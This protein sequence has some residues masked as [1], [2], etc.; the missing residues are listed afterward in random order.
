MAI[1]SKY[2][3]P[4]AL[5][6]FHLTGCEKPD[7]KASLSAGGSQATFIIDDAKG[8]GDLT[9]VDKNNAW[10]IP[11]AS[12]FS[13][14]V[15]MK[16]R[17]TRETLR[18][19][20][21]VVQ[22]EDGTEIVPEE[23]TDVNGCIKWEE[24]IPFNFFAGRSQR[25]PITRQIIG[26]NVHSGRAEV[27][28][29]VNPWAVGSQAR[30]KGEAV[31]FLRDQI[32]PKG[33]L[34]DEKMALKTLSGDTSGGAEIWL[35][36][37]DVNSIRR[38]SNSDGSVI[39][40]TFELRPKLLVKDMNGEPTY[41]E[42]KAGDFD[43]IAH[44]I[45]TDTGGNQKQ[46][47]LLT[48]KE[49]QGSAKL[50][51]GHLIVSTRTSLERRVAYGNMELALQLI[52]K[53]TGSLTNIKAY[54]GIFELGAVHE[55][56][57]GPRGIL[58]ESCRKEETRKT[59]ACSVKQALLSTSNFEEMK[60]KGEALI[61]EPY[62]FSNLKLRFAMV[63]PGE[64]AT[65]RTVLYTASTCIRD[66]F[67]GQDMADVP[68]NIDYL[69]EDGKVIPGQS[70]RRMTNEEGCLNWD[71]TIF[72][73][74]YDPER[75]FWKEIR[76]SLPNGFSRNLKFA[77]NPWDD[78]FTFGWDQREFSEQFI[79]NVQK[80][81]KIQSRF[82]LSNFG[83]H[84]VRFLYNIDR[85]MEL[86]VKKTV[87]ME[88][89]PRVLR[90][91]GIINARKQT[92]PLR[93]GI[94]LLKVGIQKDFLD[95]SDRGRLFTNK[96][97][98]VPSAMVEE[99]GGPVSRKEYITTKSQLVRVVDGQIIHPVELTMRDLRLMRIRS[100]FMIQLETVD[101]RLVTGHHVLRDQFRNDIE[102]LKK[103]RQE[104]SEMSSDEREAFL[105]KSATERKSKLESAFFMLKERLESGPP[106]LE[107][108]DLTSDESVMKL[109]KSALETNDFTEVKFPLNEDFDLNQFVEKNSG[110]EP[111][112]FVGPVIFLSNAYSDSVRATDNLDEARCDQPHDTELVE[113]GLTRNKEENP[114]GWEELKLFMD[115]TKASSASRQNNAYQFSKYY[116]SLKHLCN[117]SVDDLIAREKVMTKFYDENMPLLASIYNFASLYNLEF[118]SLK[119]EKLQ[120]LDFACTGS[121]EQCLRETSELTLSRESAVAVVNANVQRIHRP[122]SDWRT[123]DK[124][125]ALNG[126]NLNR[127]SEALFS[128][129][130]KK[131]DQ[132][133]V[134]SLLAGRA[135][136]RLSLT[137]KDSRY[138]GWWSR[139][140]TSLGHDESGMSNIIYFNCME[141]FSASEKPVFFEDRLRV[142]ETGKYTFLGG[143][144]LNLNVAEGTSMSRSDSW[145]YSIKPID[146]LDGTLVATTT[147]W[148]FLSA[149]P[150]GAMAGAVA[151]I[152][153]GVLL[154]GAADVIKPLSI[155]NGHGMS[156][157]DGTSVSQSTYIVAQIARFNIELTNYEYC[158]VIRFDPK[159]AVSVSNSMGLTQ[160]LQELV[161]RGLFVCS[162]RDGTNPVKVEEGY[163]YFTQHFTEGDM[164]DQADIY[165]HP[166]LLALRGVREFANF[167]MATNAQEVVN[168]NNFL[169][170]W[171]RPE[172]R[173]LA[174][175]LSHMEK[176]YRQVLPSFPG[177]YTL[178][179]NSEKPASFPLAER[180]STVDADINAEVRCQ[181]NANKTC[182]QK[183]SPLPTR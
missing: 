176:T 165:N 95:P 168:M 136:N 94:Y 34:V 109:L 69:D 159:F 79:A 57:R 92:E 107:N 75:L 143:L 180:L 126:L 8:T 91:S 39:D 117:K 44:L 182:E 10:Q 127:V 80:R 167:V 20:R 160:K 52:P 124:Q 36:N 123:A 24:A 32:L 88:L 157:S 45:A 134:C 142:K 156:N 166:W 144:Q 125:E 138:A 6:A 179:N 51:D 122:S 172:K 155:S 161:A 21:F 23:A 96:K 72:H 64:T 16:D 163:F 85:Y 2:L 101:E 83:Y 150:P 35:R 114:Y 26:Q 76:I 5:L 86:E 54:Q 98:E 162:G 139:N 28:F 17:A 29:A 152:S 78:K 173:S 1:S 43:V 120:K 93:D 84:T 14:F 12:S 55:L 103:R 105:Q 128:D 87:L 153:A 73:K 63:Q 7:Q 148:G 74:Y 77:L 154:K 171:W 108:F 67:T 31:V 141:A 181:L 90:Y 177:L 133:A 118:L 129:L 158:R 170:G 164:L 100:N 41:L 140:I 65:Q 13:F 60:A 146:I 169:K 11:N 46:R 40:L 116:G 121:G 102:G 106:S 147:A 89:D 27:K 145:G 149:G 58:T 62:I 115:S 61:N 111:R 132:H 151:G 15:C 47:V 30:D 9:N 49:L 131:T 110:L 37:V 174:W 104:L 183:A 81:K 38:S 178:V 22:K 68:F 113:K 18:G 137:A 53:S 59:D 3:L 119:N 130:S 56:S 82:F 25:I 97:D 175:P 4:A 71:S 135:A 19:H 42:L 112:S 33:Q 66:R 99:L 48:P 70:Q 50:Q